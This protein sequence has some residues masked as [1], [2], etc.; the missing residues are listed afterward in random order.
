MLHR[1]DRSSKGRYIHAIWLSVIAAIFINATPVLGQLN[2]E[3]IEVLRER[4]REEGWTFTV[5]EN[6]ATKYPLDKLCGLVVPDNWQA[7]ARFDPITPAKD[8]PVSF[9]WRDSNGCT[10]VKAQG[11]CGSC[12][13]FA[14][15][16]A[17]ECNIRIK[18]QMTVDLS[19]QWLVSCNQSGWGCNGGWFAHDYHQWR[20]D[21]CDSTGAVLEAD[22]PYAASDLPCNCPYP[23]RFLINS[24]AFIG[25]PSSIPA[26][27]A[28]KQAI[29]DYGPITVAVA[30]D[31]AMQAYTGGIF[32]G[33][34]AIEINHAV[35]L[36]GW[37]DTQSE[38]GIWIM[39]NSWGSG[40][41][42]QGYMRMPYGCSEIGYGACYIDYA[43]TKGLT[44]DYPNGVPITVSP[45]QTTSFEVMVSGLG[46]GEPVAGS[47]QLHY[48]ISGAAFQAEPMT[49]ISTNHYEAVLPA[50]TCSLEVE[51]YVSAEEV[52]TGLHYDPDPA[53]PHWAISAREA[54]TVFEDDFETD[55]GWTVS[56]DA[57]DGQW[58][59]GVPIG[60]GDRGDPPTDFDGSGS[61]YL[62]DNVD[63]NSDVDNGTTILDSPVFDL[64]GY[65]GI[66]HYARWYSNNYGAAPNSDEM[67]IYISSN[68]GTSWT[69]VETVGPTEQAAGGW[70]ET[71]FLAGDFITPTAQMRLRFE[72][73]DLGDGSV[74][75]A[76]VDA[77]SVIA[78]SCGTAP[79]PLTIV[80]TTLPD[81]TAGHP[82]SQTIEAVG[83]VGEYTWM[84]KHN[85]LNG[86]G[87]TLSPDGV[88]SGSPLLS[89]LISFTAIVTDQQPDT[90]EKQFGF[91]INDAISIITLSLPDWT[92]GI[93]YEQQLEAGGG[94][95]SK[96]WSDKGGDLTG[97]GLNLSS[98][99]ILSGTP[100]TSGPLE[101]TA[102]VADQVGATSER[103][104][105]ITLN[106]PVNITTESLPSC[107]LRIAYSFQIEAVG[108][109]GTRK[110]TDR[111]GVL[112]GK[113]LTLS[114]DGL[115]SGEATVTDT[116]NLIVRVEDDP[117]SFEEE[118]FDFEVIRPYI[119]GDANNDGSINVADAVFLANHVFL[120]GPAPDF[121]EAGDANAD[122]SINI[123]DSVY[124]I[125]FIFNDGEPP[126]CP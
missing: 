59:R 124:L 116:L 84:D 93:P 97:T 11:N 75:E 52:S 109:T 110:F 4:A 78:Y 94:T 105:N 58:D 70:Y 123:A 121:P 37:D 119:C 40:W 48:S 108:G 2:T 21:P 63:G 31:S 47:G 87:L 9:D 106:P 91:Y 5:G 12:W 118:S 120:D 25:N 43:G 23:H 3:D 20:T 85:N 51:F 24:W 64:T 103:P 7:A 81:W 72:A 86:T 122:G 68:G 88:L 35:V 16:G 115:L 57:A 34:D 8:I 33:C 101:F 15:V 36:V 38:S 73:S 27:S 69:L 65:D 82:F 53:S 22:F 113:G 92:V 41:G 107:S 90:D 49:E 26:I 98:T 14:T 104:F 60:G 111:D 95:G 112:E 71:I 102:E 6:P 79:D 76:A 44:F 32:N 18:D 117:G 29:L 67:K 42:E 54:F 126:R 100:L 10:P 19:E 17:F 50:V 99:G 114:E 56:G 45:D 1:S 96:T 83:G 66:I 13:A 28:M 46:I 62:T 61:C 80:T 77:V 74:V 125:N 39:R 55:K 89:G 30:A